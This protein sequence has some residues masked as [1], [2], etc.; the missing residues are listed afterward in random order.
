MFSMSGKI[1]VV[2][3]AGRGLGGGIALAYA[4][5]GADV[6]LASRTQAD[7]DEVA[8]LVRAKGRRALVHGDDVTDLAQIAALAAA[9]VAEFGRIDVW[10]NNAGGFSDVPGATTEWLE[11]SEAGWDAM[12]GLNLKAQVFGAQAAAR[13]MR[14]SGTGG[15]IIFLSS[16]DS[17][18]AAPGGEG[19]YGAC[20]A[21]INN[22]V[23]TMAVELG[24]Y[25]IPVNALSPA[26]IRTPPNPPRPPT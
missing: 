7:L 23:Q 24:H 6:V 10:V 15:S 13:A 22:I 19:I 21:A 1:C 3:G 2:T 11:I 26:G 4:E 20:K 9:A 8:G 18:Y 25:G 16:I 5:Q 14:K 12:L 17:L